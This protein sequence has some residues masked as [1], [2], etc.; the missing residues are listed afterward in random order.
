MSEPNEM[1]DET[2]D[3]IAVRVSGHDVY[4][5]FHGGV[6]GMAVVLGPEK[7]EEFAQL[8]AAACHQAKAHAEA[9]ARATLPGVTSGG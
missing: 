1:T 8:Y 2:G 5:A 3:G 7:Q 4:I 6:R 9:V